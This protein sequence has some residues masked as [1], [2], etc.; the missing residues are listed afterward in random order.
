MLYKLGVTS[1]SL[2]LFVGSQGITTSKCLG[3]LVVNDVVT[4]EKK[5]V[6]VNTLVEITKFNFNTNKVRI[7]CIKDLHSYVVEVGFKFLLDHCTFEDKLLTEPINAVFAKYYIQNV[8]DKETAIFVI[9]MVM[10]YICGMFI[11]KVL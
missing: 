7:K 2:A 4:D 6:D 5:E 11:G 10:T 3:N 1:K 9:V 8:L